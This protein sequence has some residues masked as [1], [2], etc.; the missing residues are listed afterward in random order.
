M[1]CEWHCLTGDPVTFGSYLKHLTLKNVMVS[2]D[3]DWPA[4][5][6]LHAD[7]VLQKPCLLVILIQ[8]D[9]FRSSLP[10]IVVLGEDAGPA[11][12]CPGLPARKH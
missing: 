11:N 8:P 12:T 4:G 10:F 9:L 5:L 7:W 2:D 3:V 1:D 6:A